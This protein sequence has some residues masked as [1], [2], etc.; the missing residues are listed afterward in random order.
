M[1]SYQKRGLLLS[2][3]L[4]GSPLVTVSATSSSLCGTLKDRLWQESSSVR[5]A[6]ENI[7]HSVMTSENRTSSPEL[8]LGFDISLTGVSTPW[9]L[10]AQLE[11]CEKAL[12]FWQKIQHDDEKQWTPPWSKVCTLVGTPSH[13]P[14]ASLW[15]HLQTLQVVLSDPTQAASVLGHPGE[16]ATSSLYGVMQC[17]SRALMN[18]PL[19][20]LLSAKNPERPGLKVLLSDL[21]TTVRERCAS[22]SQDPSLQTTAELILRSMGSLEKEAP[23]YPESCLSLAKNLFHLVDQHPFLSFRTFQTFYEAFGGLTEESTLCPSEN[24]REQAYEHV[25]SLQALVQKEGTT[26]KDLLPFFSHEEEELSLRRVLLSLRENLI[27]EVLTWAG[28]EGAPRSEMSLQGHVRLLFDRWRT[29]KNDIGL[30]LNNSEDRVRK[31]LLDV[32]ASLERVASMSVTLHLSETLKGFYVTLPEQMQ[33]IAEQLQA[34]SLTSNKTLLQD[35]VGFEKDVLADGTLLGVLGHIAS[36]LLTAPWDRTF[37]TWPLSASLSL[38]PYETLSSVMTDLIQTVEAAEKTTTTTF[39]RREIL[40]DEEGKTHETLAYG[41]RWFDFLLRRLSVEDLPDVLTFA[42]FSSQDLSSWRD[43]LDTLRRQLP[44]DLQEHEAQALQEFFPDISKAVY[45]ESGTTWT[46]ALWDLL[47]RFFSLA[48]SATLGS[49][50]Q[51]RPNLGCEASLTAHLAYWLDGNRVNHLLNRPLSPV[52]QGLARQSWQ[53][54]SFL[55]G[56][57]TK[58][59]DLSDSKKFLF[60]EKMGTPFAPAPQTIWKDLD[61]WEQALFSGSEDSP[62]KGAAFLQSLRSLRKSLQRPLQR[63]IAFLNEGKKSV[64]A[65]AK[66]VPQLAA[67]L[68]SEEQMKTLGEL[69][70]ALTSTLNQLLADIFTPEVKGKE[71]ILEKAFGVFQQN[72]TQMLNVLEAKIPEEIAWTADQD[73]NNAFPRSIENLASSLLDLTTKVALLPPPRS[74][75]FGSF[76]FVRED[77]ERCATSLHELAQSAALQQHLEEDVDLELS[78]QALM[79]LAEAIE[80]CAEGV[81]AV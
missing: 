38:P 56:G 42:A 33:Q 18:E 28:S 30:G 68:P 7:R 36:S 60:L 81:D 1:T 76:S 21:E 37:G 75:T 15:G 39:I 77:L 12:A 9:N 51:E 29:L 44:V 54:L 74:P 80:R 45:E 47:R 73:E 23:M 41:L 22:W 16:D 26:P 35:V 67:N 24:I 27:S 13:P 50:L 52:D 53:E 59:E 46:H 32:A 64:E 69:V 25:R 11:N 66:R 78:R 34:V 72:L 63:T 61:T 5:Q 2:W 48:W 55:A 6:L 8:A 57:G 70:S 20:A 14:A 31:K 10:F 40:G 58:V 17:L 49:S 65:L 79:N 4:V 62:S 71:E 3:L 19:V 43:R